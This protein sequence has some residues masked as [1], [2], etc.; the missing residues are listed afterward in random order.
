MNAIAKISSPNLVDH[1][2]A[3]PALQSMASD[4]GLLTVALAE[5]NGHIDGIDNVL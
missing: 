1:A 2:A 5:V 3:N 4:A